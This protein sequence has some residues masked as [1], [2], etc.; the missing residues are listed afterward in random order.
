MAPTWGLVRRLRKLRNDQLSG[1]MLVALGAFVFW[2]N[3]AYP[4]GS[5]H[6]PGPGY[7]PLLIALFLAAIGLLI[8]LAG[9]KSQPVAEVSWPEARR[10]IIIVAAC[11]VALIALERIGYRLTIAALM[12]FFLGVLER[13]KPLRVAAVSIGF[14]MLSYYI[15]GTLL[16]VPLPVGP[17]GF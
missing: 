17:W 13:R 14:S 12:I 15:V 2:E 6:E 1:L 16:H 8:T 4:L 10:A 9:G 5:L 3:R 7:M 11:A